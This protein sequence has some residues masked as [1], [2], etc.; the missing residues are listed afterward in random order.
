PQH[1]GVGVAAFTA[2]AAN[3]ARA[4]VAGLNPIVG[5]GGTGD[6]N[7]A[8]RIGPA[9]AIGISGVAACA[10]RPPFAAGAAKEE[11]LTGYTSD[12]TVAADA[13]GIAGPAGDR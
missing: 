12:A 10:S 1:I 11:F 4:A 5:D 7:I 13:A 2:V 3:A 8:A 6:G 9:A